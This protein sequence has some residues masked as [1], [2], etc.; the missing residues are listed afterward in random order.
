M[1]EA[2]IANDS[3]A[4]VCIHGLG[5]QNLTLMQSLKADDTARGSLGSLASPSLDRLLGSVDPLQ[6]Q[7]L[8]A[9]YQAAQRSSDPVSSECCM[10]GWLP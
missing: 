1:V 5:H 4:V 9:A 10:F 8:L 6:R 3:S 7:Q 2:T